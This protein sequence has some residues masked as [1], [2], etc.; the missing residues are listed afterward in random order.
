MTPMIGR[1][2]PP[3]LHV[4]T[5]NIR[6]R[7]VFDPRR[8]DRWD[9][10]RN[11]LRTL[12]TAEAPTVLGVQE[13]MPDQAEF[14]HSSLGE[15]YRSVGRGRDRDGGGEACPLFYDEERLELVDSTQSALSEHPDVAGSRSWGSAFPRIVVTASFFDRATS[16]RFVVLNTHLDPFSAR[17]RVRSSEMVRDLAAAAAHPAIVLGDLNAAPDSPA[18]RALLAGDSL[19]DAWA[20][21]DT[22]VTPEWGTFANYRPPR[23]GS[24]RIDW[25]A[26]SN[27]VRVKRVGV[28]A[29]AAEGNWPSDHLPV[30]A[31]LRLSDE[32]STR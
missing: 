17:A 10:R 29:S 14:V 11:P 1:I 13:A 15:R 16:T 20:A 12:L 27:G 32:S 2:E 21:A 31:V 22:R 5:Y 30:Q 19:R 24:G 3:D 6:R 26:V 4:M 28:N 9:A 8:A 7:V 23:A 18:V 25:I